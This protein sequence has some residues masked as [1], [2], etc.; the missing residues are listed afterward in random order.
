MAQDTKAFRMFEDRVSLPF[1][2]ALGPTMTRFFD[3]FKEKKI[4]G[5]KCPSCK[6]VFVMKINDALNRAFPQR[7]DDLFERRRSARADCAGNMREFR[8]VRERK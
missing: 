7:G 2:Y 3:E 5:T 8:P 6:K 4:M 1:R